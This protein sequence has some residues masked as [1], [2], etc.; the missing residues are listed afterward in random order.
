MAA[1]RFAEAAPLYAQLVKALPANPGLRLNLALAL[2]MSGKSAEAIPEFERVIKAMPNNVPALLSL[3]MARLERNEP[4]KAVAPLD[5]VVALDPAN[6]D[7]RGMLANALLSQGQAKQ[8]AMHFRKLTAATPQDPKAW[9][10]LGRSYETQA[11]QQFE[12]LSKTGEGS[13]EWLAL[14]ADSRVERGQFRSAFYFYQQAL[15]KNPALP[16]LHAALANVYHRTD[17][18]DWAASELKKEPKLAGAACVQKKAACDYAAGRLVEAASSNSPYWSIKASNDLAR[19][20]F[21]KLGDLPPSAELHALQAEIMSTHDQHAEAVKQ[22]REAEKLAPG[23]ARIEKSIA[24]E[25]YQARDYASAI[26]A[27]QALARRGRDDEAVLLALGD[28]YL[29]LEQPEKAVEPLEKALA[30]DPKLG[31]AHA[32]LG[33]ALMRLNRA[34]AAVPHLEAALAIDD[35]GSL[36]YQLARAYQ[37]AGKSEQSQAMMKDYQEIQKRSEAQ[38]QELE[39]TAQIT[40]PAP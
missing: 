5:K 20:A 33:L 6:T 34:A 30:F 19:K 39:E 27:L 3:G 24:V 16:G 36:H 17:H 22:W 4:A 15:A 14:I 9:M 1:G 37:A 26:P 35:D 25:L 2:Q 10:G 13:A 12:A 29:R 40:A 8:A 32:S 38:K 31:P 18:A 7:A 28:S 21:A 23:D 11:Q